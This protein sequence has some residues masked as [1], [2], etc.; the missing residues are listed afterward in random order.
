MQ[1]VNSRQFAAMVNR[2]WV[3][4]ELS[5]RPCITLSY[6]QK[7]YCNAGSGIRCWTRY[8]W[9]LKALKIAFFKMCVSFLVR[10][11]EAQGSSKASITPFRTTVIIWAYRNW[12]GLLP[13]LWKFPVVTTGRSCFVI[14]G[15]G[16][17][18][19]FTFN[20]LLLKADQIH[21]LC[22]KKSMCPDTISPI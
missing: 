20:T 13:P 15:L 6:I 3:M 7:A 10:K 9:G 12:F 18:K 11:P 14:W 22:I 1:R 19:C 16:K 17:L 5:A 2:Y 8:S 21:K 4:W